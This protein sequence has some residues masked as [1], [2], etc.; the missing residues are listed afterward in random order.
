MKYLI[1]APTDKRIIH[2]SDDLGYQ[3]N[4]NYLIN[5][6]RL[7]IPPSICELV[8]VDNVPDGVEPEKYCY[9]DNAFVENPNWSEPVEEEYLTPDEVISILT[10]EGT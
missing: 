5:N 7:A 3:S 9:I 6:G 8:T 1:L 2:I 4:G 10:G